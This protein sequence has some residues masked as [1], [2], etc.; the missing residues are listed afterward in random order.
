MKP[1]THNVNKHEKKRPGK[2]LQQ[3]DHKQLNKQKNTYL[4]R[5]KLKNHTSHNV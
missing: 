4:L 5:V 2:W 1:K 3:D